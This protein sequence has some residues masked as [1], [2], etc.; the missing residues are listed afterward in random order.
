MDCTSTD[1][2]TLTPN[3][4]TLIANPTGLAVKQSFYLWCT[5]DSTARTF[6]YGDN[7]IF[8]AGTPTLPTGA[9]DK[10]LI[11]GTRVAAGAN[12]IICGFLG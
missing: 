11:T 7:F 2:H 10:F 5:Q 1:I 4:N 6:T 9:G 3:Q 8:P 12:G